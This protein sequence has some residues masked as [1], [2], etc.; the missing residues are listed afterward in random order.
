MMVLRLT[1]ARRSKAG[2]LLSLVYLLCV[3]APTIS[4]ALPGSHAVAPCL[5]D[6]I[7]VPGMVHAHTEVPT[8][9]VHSDSQGRDHFDWQSHAISKGAQRSTS[10]ALNGK[11]VPAKAPHSSAGQCCGLTCITALPATLINIVKPSGPTALCE[12]EGCRK[13]TD[14]A[15]SRL[16]RPPISWLD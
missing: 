14:N 13:V 1:R 9:H 10:I 8:R 6:A 15:P 2:W 12:V 5:A 11:V 4:F 3:L 7:H 16:Y